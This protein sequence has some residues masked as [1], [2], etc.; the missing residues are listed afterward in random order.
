M[1]QRL[2]DAT[3]D[4]RAPQQSQIGDEEIHRAGISSEWSPAQRRPRVDAPWT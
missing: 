3:A 1:R 2:K 4:A